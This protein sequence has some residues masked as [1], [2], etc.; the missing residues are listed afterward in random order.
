[1]AVKLVRAPSATPNIYN[2]DDF[3][4][5]RYSYGDNNGYVKGVSRHNVNHHSTV[6]VALVPVDY[7]KTALYPT[8]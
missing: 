7:H 4:G 8:T 5:L 2:T 1:M 6:F 3:V